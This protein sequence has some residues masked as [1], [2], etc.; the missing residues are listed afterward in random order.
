M[1]RWTLGSWEKKLVID[2]M[3]FGK[4]LDII[5]MAVEDS[6]NLDIESYNN[7]IWGELMWG[8]TEVEVRRERCKMESGWQDRLGSLLESSRGRVHRVEG[9]ESDW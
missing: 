5:K 8:R 4:G 3:L 1:G 7:L 2:Y 9:G 6:G